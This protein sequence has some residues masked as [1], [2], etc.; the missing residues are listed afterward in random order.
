MWKEEGRGEDYVSVIVGRRAQRGGGGGRENY[1]AGRRAGAWDNRARMRGRVR[2]SCG[3]GAKQRG[4]E[5]GGILEE[6]AALKDPRA[7]K[8]HAVSR[9]GGERRGGGPFF[10]HGVG[11]WGREANGVARA[12]VRGAEKGASSSARGSFSVE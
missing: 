3:Y 12:G 8:G 1:G 7:G 11:A 10:L 5:R 4:R 9:G 6:G 2:L